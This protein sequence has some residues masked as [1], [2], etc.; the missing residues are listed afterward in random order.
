V[1]P[2]G[3]GSALAERRFERQPI[4]SRAFLLPRTPDP[5]LGPDVRIIPYT[6]SFQVSDLEPYLDPLRH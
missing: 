6:S 3:A 4:K 5:G 1:E 2:A